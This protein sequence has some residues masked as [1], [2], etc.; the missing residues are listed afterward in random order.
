MLKVVTCGHIA[1]AH[2]RVTRNDGNFVL[3]F[4]FVVQKNDTCDVLAAS[5]YLT[6]DGGIY[7]DS[8]C[9]HRLCDYDNPNI[10]RFL[11]VIVAQGLLGSELFDPT[12]V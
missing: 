2:P 5:I 10:A 6:S 11:G 1:N 3:E 12:G 8:S 7:T 4:P 9:D